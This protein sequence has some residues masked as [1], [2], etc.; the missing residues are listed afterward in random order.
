MQWEKKLNERRK[1]KLMLRKKIMIKAESRK[2]GDYE[3]RNVQIILVDIYLDSRS[4]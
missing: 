2:G 4:K 3:L 1:E